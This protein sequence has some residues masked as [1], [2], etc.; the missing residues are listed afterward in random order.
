MQQK[1]SRGVQQH[2]VNVAADALLAERARPT[3]ERVRMKLGRGSPNTVGPLLETWFASLATRLGVRSDEHPDKGA[4]P[5]ALRQALHDVWAEALASAHT[6]AAAGMAQERAQLSEEISALELARAELQ[7]GEAE[8]TARGAAMQQTLELATARLQEKAGQLED[9]RAQLA[10][11]RASLAR[12]VEERDAER[13]RLDAQTEA[14]CQE[15]D[16]LQARENST[17]RRL[18]EEVDR[19]RQEAKHA[20]AELSERIRRNEVALE[21]ARRGQHMAMGVESEA[22]VEMVAL[23]ERLAAAEQRTQDLREQL[24]VVRS[25]PRA[26]VGSARKAGASR[27]KPRGANV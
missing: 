17:E 24:G 13:R 18:L 10:Q 27:R 14:A 21:E 9:L 26:S 15:R 4:T 1:S 11:A 2:D 25:A 16:R 5:P 23:R 3:V 6:E 8:L 20:R 7:R 12:L 19:A 22:R